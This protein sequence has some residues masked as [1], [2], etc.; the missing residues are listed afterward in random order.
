VVDR[1]KAI[2]PALTSSLPQEI[3][4][5]IL[6]DRTITVRASVSDAL[7]DLFI[8]VCLVVFVVFLFLRNFS[9][10]LIPALRCLCLWW[11]F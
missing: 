4:V 2:L 10:T 6:N 3:T 9:A 7:M 1:I 8:S 11:Y 5:S